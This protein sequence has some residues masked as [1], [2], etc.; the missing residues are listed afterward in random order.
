[1]ASKRSKPKVM[2]ICRREV[3]LWPLMIQLNIVLAGLEMVEFMIHRK[4]QREAE[5]KIVF[6]IRLVSIPGR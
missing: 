3:F 2:L 4:Q 5:G 1:M 6:E